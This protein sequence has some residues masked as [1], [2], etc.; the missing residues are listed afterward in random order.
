[1]FRL[2]DHPPMIL[3]LIIDNVITPSDIQ[4][5]LTGGRYM[6]KNYYHKVYKN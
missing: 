2:E 1:M 6:L 5:I 4:K 3:S